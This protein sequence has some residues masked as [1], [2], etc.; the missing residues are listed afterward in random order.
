M[1][2]VAVLV[3]IAEIFGVS[4]DYLI[5]EHAE[6]EKVE[7]SDDKKQRRGLIVSLITFFALLAAEIIVFLGLFG[8]VN[9]RNVFLFCFVYPLPIWAIIGIVFSTV[10]G[11]KFARFVAVSILLVFLT[12]DAFL[13]VELATGVFYYLIFAVLIPAL[14]IVYFSFYLSGNFFKRKNR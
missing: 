5:T 14:G 1:P 11:S 9:S 4:V 13:I 10:W 12:L 6:D 7:L 2:D 8:F 3:A